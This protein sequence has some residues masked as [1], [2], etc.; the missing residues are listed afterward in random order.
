MS[1]DF[2]PMK[3][4][5]NV[6]ASHKSCDGGAGNTGYF[7]RDNN[8]E[9]NEFKFFTKDLGQ[10]SF[11]K[12]KIPEKEEENVSF[13]ILFLKFIEDLIDKLTNFFSQKFKKI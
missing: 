4:L 2:S 6:Q 5:S 9:E 1:F 8:E 3:N 7:R 11:V 12:S 13:F 10:D